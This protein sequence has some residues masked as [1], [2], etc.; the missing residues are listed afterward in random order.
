MKVAEK[1]KGQFIA[2]IIKFRSPSGTDDYSHKIFANEKHYNQI[3][4]MELQGELP[5][6]HEILSTYYGV[7]INSATHLIEKAVKD[8]RKGKNLDLDALLSN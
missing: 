7:D 5:N 1:Y 2:Q 3:R 8:L 6:I 4:M